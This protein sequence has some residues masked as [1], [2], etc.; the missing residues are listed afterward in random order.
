MLDQEGVLRAH[1]LASGPLGPRGLRE[2]ESVGV[3]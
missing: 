3:R 2:I 1:F